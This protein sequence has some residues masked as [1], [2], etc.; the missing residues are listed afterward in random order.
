MTEY[1]DTNGTYADLTNAIFVALDEL[2]LQAE[3]DCLPP[4]WRVP[5]PFPRFP[6]TEAL[7]PADIRRRPVR[8]M[9]ARR[10]VR[11]RPEV[12]AA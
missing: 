11:M 7:S 6:R 5:L 12:R 1:P 8:A 3:D 9:R 4:P 2:P 10:E